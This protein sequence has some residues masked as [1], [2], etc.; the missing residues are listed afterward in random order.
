MNAE[1]SS[2][3]VCMEWLAHPGATRH[4]IG[5]K[6]GMCDIAAPPPGSDIV[7]NGNDGS[8]ML[9]NAIGCLD[10]AHPPIPDEKAY[11]C[12]LSI[13]DLLSRLL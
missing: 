5:F 10:V 11:C 8:T 12:R 7:Q 13:D 6:D 2:S 9:V 4:A 1:Q 3:L